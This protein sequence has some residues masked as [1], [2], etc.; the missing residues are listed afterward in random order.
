[1]NCRECSKVIPDGFT[2]C[3]WC[4]A[5]PGN[6][7]A[8]PARDAVS[9]HPVASPVHDSLIGMSVLSS[10][11]LFMALNYFAMVRDEGSLTL[12]NSAYF[13]GRCAGSIILAAILVFVYFKIRGQKP[14]S[15]IQLLM[16]FSL[17]SLLTLLAMA[18]PA[19]HRLATFDPATLRH[20]G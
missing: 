16:I 5:V 20:Y 4:G 19:R 9:T 12:A 3:P 14:R 2:D 15:A 11:I 17:S 6:V 1:M 10:A 13:L 18:S 8:A 7:A